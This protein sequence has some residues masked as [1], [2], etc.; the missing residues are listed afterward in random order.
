MAK[1]FAA[2]LIQ[3]TVVCGAA[4]VALSLA[5]PQPPRPD[6][7]AALPGAVPESA[8]VSPPAEPVPAETAAPELPPE[9]TAAEAKAPEAAPETPSETALAAAPE[10][11]PAEPD[12]VA[13]GPAT[14]SLLVP[15][16]SEFARSTDMRPQVPAPLAEA[17]RVAAA[18][19]VALPADEPAPAT[20]EP[21]RLR[22]EARGE[23]PAAPALAAPEND[24]IDLPELAGEAPIPVPPPGKVVVPGL[25]RAPGGPVLLPDST[26]V[27]P[28]APVTSVAAAPEP[29]PE[30]APEAPVETPAE[31]ELAVAPQPAPIPVAQPVAAPAPSDPAAPRVAPDLSLPP[32]FGALRLTE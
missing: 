7:V 17:P 16:G 25:D 10:A 19:T 12:A 30:P 13:P 27:A 15:A 9:T 18:P 4:L 11:A 3:G 8:A 1:G 32:D 26:P 14:D 29:A 6:Q 21:D 31:P 5:L 24:P 20:A 2:G 22:P 23:A 28:V